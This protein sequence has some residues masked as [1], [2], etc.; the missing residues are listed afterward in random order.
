ME[1]SSSVT[2][3]KLGAKLKQAREQ[4]GLSVE[5]VASSLKLLPRIIENLESDNYQALPELVFIKGYVRLYAELLHLPSQDLCADLDAQ[6]PTTPSFKVQALLPV[7]ELPEL[8]SH[9]PSSYFKLSHYSK[10]TAS[11]SWFVYVLG[12]V[13]IAAMAIGVWQSMNLRAKKTDSVVVSSSVQG[14]NVISLPNVTTTRA[15]TDVLQLQ[16]SE[17]TK[18][19]IKDAN[20]TELANT[21]SKAGDTLTVK[22]ESPFAI[23]LNPAHAVQFTFND[24]AIDL[25]PYIVN[26]VVNFRLSR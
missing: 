1:Q 7:D 2:T 12:L 23:E 17:P 4:Q 20:G 24:K 3:L 21:M 8:A 13:L 18:V 9:Q 11:K 26:D 10:N 5:T 16:F 14:Q 15:V 6:S 22:G 19:Y 25:K